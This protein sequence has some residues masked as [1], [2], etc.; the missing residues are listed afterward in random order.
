MNS[1]F[2][3]QPY[4]LNNT[5]CDVFEEY[6]EF[7]LPAVATVGLNKA[8][9]AQRSLVSFLNHTRKF[10]YAVYDSYV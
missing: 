7:L 2:L 4:L 10:C 6:G 1:G 9:Q 5:G 8:K 3:K